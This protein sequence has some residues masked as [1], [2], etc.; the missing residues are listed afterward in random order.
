MAAAHGLHGLAAAHGLHGLAAAHGL[1]G[2]AAARRGTTQLLAAAAAAQGL[3]GFAAAHG[4]HGLAA[5]QGLH[6][7]A[8]AHGLHGFE[9]AATWNGDSAP[10]GAMPC[11]TA[12]PTPTPITMGTTVVERSRLRNVMIKA[13]YLAIDSARRDCTLYRRRKACKGYRAF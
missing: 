10:A 5:A 8:A 12:N 3:H 7:F 11:T 6:G 13:P 9:A 2:L 1:H 4:L